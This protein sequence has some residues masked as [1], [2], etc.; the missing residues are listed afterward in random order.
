[1]VRLLRVAQK[2]GYPATMAPDGYQEVTIL[3][4]GGYNPEVIVVQH[5]RPVLLRFHEEVSAAYTEIAAIGDPGEP[6]LAAVLHPGETV[7]VGSLSGKRRPNGRNNEA[8]GR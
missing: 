5:G 1:M 3:D 8:A 6:T 2:D 7:A 4:S